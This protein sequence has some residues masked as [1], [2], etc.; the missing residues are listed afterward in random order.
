MWHTSPLLQAKHGFSQRFGGVG[1]G[2]YH[3]L[4]LSTRVGDDPN[5]VLENRRLALGALGIHAAQP[6]LLRQIHSSVVV[7]ASLAAQAAEPMPADAL[8]CNTLG[9]LLVIETADCYP[10]L[11]EDSVA[12][13]VAAAHCGWRGTAGRI[14][15][16]TVAAMQT[17]G[18][19]PE[20]IRAAIGPGICAAQYPVR[21][22]VLERLEEAGFPLGLLVQHEGLSSSGS[23]L[24]HLDLAAANRW[25]L[26]SLGLLPEQIW[27][28]GQCSTQAPYF[29][30]RRD[31]G[32]TGRMWAVI[33]SLGA[34]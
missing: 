23:R 9:F 18:A 3:S 16:Q 2:V 34:P 26:G 15:E 20:R 24:F 31:H 8:V 5:H 6:V 22:D 4:N 27:L 30:Y 28:A 11:L 33:E 21:L 17:H 7:D 10:V 32:Q 25:L 19:S 13:V 29:S 14:L 12:G 1:V